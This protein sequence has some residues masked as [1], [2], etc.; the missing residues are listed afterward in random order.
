MTSACFRLLT[1]LLLSWLSKFGSVALDLAAL[2]KIQQTINNS[3][4]HHGHAGDQLTPASS[5]FL[6]G[7]WK[8]IIGDL[9][10]LVLPHAFDTNRL[11]NFLGNVFDS[12]S[13]AKIAGLHYIGIRVN[14]VGHQNSPESFFD[15]LPLIYLNPNPSPPEKAI[16]LVKKHC[17]CDR[18][19]WWVTDLWLPMIR[20]VVRKGLYLHLSMRDE[21]GATPEFK[22]LHIQ[23]HDIISKVAKGQALPFYPDVAIHY[24]FSDN[25]FGGMGLLSIGT[26]IDRIPSHA[27][28]IYV[29]TDSPQRLPNTP[30][31]RTCTDVLQGIFDDL[32]RAFPN[33]IIVLKRGGNE[34]TIW[35]QFAF[36]NIT[37]CSPSTYCLWPAIAREGVT[38]MAA[39]AYVGSVR[40]SQFGVIPY[41]EQW[42]WIQNPKIYN[43]FTKESTALEI[44]KT[45]RIDLPDNI[46][47]KR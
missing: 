31:A 29:F 37:I 9:P 38:Y 27:K 1:L 32:Q 4:V 7:F 21:Y 33:A 15:A 16:E 22:R 26:L 17:P 20:S 24:R 42:Y 40:Q 25:V 47:E 18:Y 19:C 11:G 44:L 36:A 10:I 30:F 14:Y 6:R 39:T 45:I 12:L 46:R 43:N 5:I 23:E 8:P 35:A 2:Y 13:C 41:H 34:V 3:S 28:Y